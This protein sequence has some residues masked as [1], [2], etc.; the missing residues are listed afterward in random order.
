MQL[1]FCK[2]TDIL[3]DHIILTDKWKI[4]HLKDV[5]RLKAGDVIIACNNKGVRYS[6]KIAQMDREKIILNIA[7]KLDSY[8]RHSWITAACAIPK[9]SRMDDIVDKLTQLGV[10]SIIPLKTER[11]VVRLDKHNEQTK[12]KRWSRIAMASAEQSRRATIPIIEMVKDIEGAL[13]DSQEFSLKLIF[14]LS[15]QRKK[16]REVIDERGSSST[17]FFIGPEGDFTE[18]EV[19]LAQKYGCIPLNLGEQVLRVETAAIAVASFLMLYENS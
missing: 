12:L 19:L 1:V 10:D 4:H 3:S 9:K 18:R 6:C 5:L 17:I 15:G 8:K 7:D 13:K 11:T 14:T 16:L 2:D